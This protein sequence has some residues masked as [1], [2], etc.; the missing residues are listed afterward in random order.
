MTDVMTIM[1]EEYRALRSESLASMK[2]QQATVSTGTGALA[3][4]VGL[5]FRQ[6]LPVQSLILLMPIPALSYVVLLIWLGE[7][8]RMMRAGFYLATIESRVNTYCLV[9]GMPT[10]LGWESWLRQ[11]GAKGRT[12]QVD[13]NYKAIIGLFLATSLGS[14]VLAMVRDGVHYDRLLVAF[15]I[16]IAVWV[17]AFVVALRLGKSLK[18]C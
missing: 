14:V 15:I 17:A 12:P 4:L 16:E 1:L 8:A 10:A 18:R 7:V 3:V 9:R 13:W 6:T 11:K 5:A 2:S